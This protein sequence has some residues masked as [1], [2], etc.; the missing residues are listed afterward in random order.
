[1]GIGGVQQHQKRLTDLLQFPDDT[2]LRLQIVLPGNVCDGTVGGDDDAHGGVVG[3]DLT[4]ADLRRLGHGDLVVV[5]RGHHHAGRQIF[6]LAHGA[7][8]H[9]A[10]AV[11]EPHGEGHVILQSDADSLLRH[12]L[13][14]RGHDGAAGA[15]LRQFIL[16]PVA[17]VRIVDVGQDL[18]L[19]EALDEG[20]FTR[21][22]RAYHP[23]IDT[24][25]RA[26]RHILIDGCGSIHNAFLRILTVVLSL[27]GGGVF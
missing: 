6:E 11:D 20:G 1:M 3:D 18:R 4:G 16:R 25:A 12:E 21:P 19:H 17:A 22:H 9:V 23:D 8:H 7:G 26:G 14:L 15:A 2:F 10:H 13:W 5:P 27:C 24:A